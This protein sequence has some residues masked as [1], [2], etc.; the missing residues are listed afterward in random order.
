[1]KLD[2]AQKI[3]YLAIELCECVG[4]SAPTQEEI[5]QVEQQLKGIMSRLGT[6]LLC[7]EDRLCPSDTMQQ[8]QMG[9]KEEPIKKQYRLKDRLRALLNQ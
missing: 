4:M 5:G 6:L 2:K 1:M 3:N 9:V 8:K 7:I